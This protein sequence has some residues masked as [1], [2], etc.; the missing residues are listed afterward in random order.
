MIVTHDPR[1]AEQLRARRPHRG[2]PAS[3]KIGSTERPMKSRLAGINK[4]LASLRE[5]V[6]DGVVD[7]RSHRS[8]SHP[9]A[10]GHRPRRGLGGG[11]LRA[12][13]RR[14]A[15]DDGVLRPHRRH[16]QD[17]HPQPSGHQGPVQTAAERNS[18]GLTYDDALALKREATT[19]EL[20]EPTMERS[21]LV[22]SPGYEKNAGD[23]GEPPPPTSPC[24]TSTPRR[25]GSSPPKTSPR[26]RRW[27]CWAP[28]AAS[29][30]SGD[31]RRWARPSTSE[32]AATR[33]WGSWRRRS[34]TSTPP[35]TTAWSG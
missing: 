5:S 32:A 3:K 17:V 31:D 16:P 1:I 24:T 18:K 6:V 8:R 35:T 28:P 30:S 22:K 27:W 21:E 13:R 14:Q 12:H 29:R 33:W 11:D 7:I 9:P 10:R 2:R 25:A 34:S 23:R 19:L 15:P 4:H 26:A 20:V